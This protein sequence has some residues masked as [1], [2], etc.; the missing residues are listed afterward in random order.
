MAK[1]RNVMVAA[2]RKAPV[3]DLV[4]GV[5]TVVMLVIAGVES[6]LFVSSPQVA[7]KSP[8]DPGSIPAGISSGAVPPNSANAAP[9]AMPAAAT[10]RKS[11][12]A[13]PHAIP[14]GLPKQIV[15]P[16]STLDLAVQHQFKDATLYVWVD[17]K[18][19]LTR[20]LHGA[21][22]KKLVVFS[23]VRGV[24]SETLNI[25]AGKHVLRL[26]TLSAD[27]AIDLSRTI[28]ADFIGGGDKS[29]QVT[30]DKRN[31]TMHLAWQ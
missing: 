14:Q 28:S 12:A 15:V 24:D 22:E 11:H 3:R 1:V 31:S 4:L 13:T 29:L 25:P 7:M 10:P 6:K 23:G 2:L 30:F 20:P 26:R 16:L 17:D 18:L 19:M 21:T 9:A 8:V 5:M 27:H